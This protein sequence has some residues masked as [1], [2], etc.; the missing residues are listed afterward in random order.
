MKNLKVRLSTPSVNS[1]ELNKIKTLF[2]N[3]WLGYGPNV[4]KFENLWSKYFNVR[5]SI[6]VNSC[7]AALHLSLLGL[8][9]KKKEIVLVS[10]ITF[11][12]AVNAIT[13]VGAEPILFDCDKNTWQIDVNLIRRFLEKESYMKFN[14]SYYKKTNQRISAI[15]PVHIFGHPCQRR[16]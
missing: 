6:G 12:A 3:S 14:K 8:G 10:N 5:Y 1:K 16:W 7:T 2:Q 15:L 11:I 13:Y 9:V 4:G